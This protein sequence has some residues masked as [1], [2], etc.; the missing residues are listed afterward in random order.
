MSEK[1]YTSLEDQYQTVNVRRTREEITTTSSVE[2]ILKKIVPAKSFLYR[3]QDKKNDRI[4][5]SYLPM[6]SGTPKKP[7]RFFRMSSYEYPMFSSKE[8]KTEN[9]NDRGYYSVKTNSRYYI[10]KTFRIP[11]AKTKYKSMTTPE[12][13]SESAVEDH[14]YE[15]LCYTDVEKEKTEEE[16]RDQT[17][18]PYKV[19]IQELFQSFK[20]PFF[21]KNEDAEVKEDAKEA[22]EVVDEQKKETDGNF[23]ENGDVEVAAN[24][25]DSVHAVRPVEGAEKDRV[26][27]PVEDYLEPIQVER[28]HQYCDV[29][30]KEDSLLQYIMNLFEN[31][32]M[33][34]ETNEETSEA[35]EP[36][37]P[38]EP[39]AEWTNN[40]AGRPLPV[41]VE[42]EPYYMQ[43][44]RSEA[45]DLLRGEPDGVFLLRPSSQPNHAYTLSVSCAG[46][47][48]N[49]GVRKR[50]D[51]RLALG[52]PRRGERGFTSIASLLR[53][54]KRRRLLLV[55][56]G[57]VVGATTLNEPPRYYQT[58]SSIPV[59]VRTQ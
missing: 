56:G 54:H 34:R 23:Y 37:K 35:L 6:D 45:E 14:L 5:S 15:D 10:Q 7:R 57:G 28:D 1:A 26:Q 44:S 31:F 33:R 22:V 49:V 38:E 53:H 20:L 21:K 2:E 8:T 29:A 19:M 55:A 3:N 52:Y 17:Q 51:G 47:V 16:K 4:F 30:L 32:G 41:P 12:E 48:H 9:H 25:Y 46:G 18:K 39:P 36:R 13:V 43:V 40:M 59:P 24:M 42:N 50:S 11:E 27:I 58:P